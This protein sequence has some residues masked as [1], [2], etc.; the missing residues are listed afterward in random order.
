[1]IHPHRHHHHHFHDFYSNTYPKYEA[2]TSKEREHDLYNMMHTVVENNNVI[3]KHR[4]YYDISGN[5]NPLFKTNVLCCVNEGIS[6]ELSDSMIHEFGVILS[7]QEA[8]VML[9]TPIVNIVTNSQEVNDHMINIVGTALSS[10]TLCSQLELGIGNVIS[11][12]NIAPYVFNATEKVLQNDEISSSLI[13]P[14]LNVIPQNDV[15]TL[16]V[17]TVVNGVTINMIIGNEGIPNMKDENNDGIPDE[18]QDDNNG[19][20]EKSEGGE[21]DEPEITT[22]IWG[23]MGA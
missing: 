21:D 22:L 23:G 20:S 6:A 5:I 4:L 8:S 18:Y 2:Y 1:M 17:N 13:K 16:L 14:I 3:F 19:S 11:G 7:S 15:S 12:D 10:E 9:S